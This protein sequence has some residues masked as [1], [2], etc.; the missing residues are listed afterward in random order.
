MSTCP[1]CRSKNIS[2]IHTDPS[3]C[4]EMIFV[5]M[6]CHQ[7]ECKWTQVYSCRALI[8]ITAPYLTTFAN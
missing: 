3:E 1:T 5:K 8:D 7:C 2:S 6:E 4:G